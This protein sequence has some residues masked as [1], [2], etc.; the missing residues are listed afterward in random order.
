MKEKIYN[1]LNRTYGICMMVSFFAGG[2]PIIPFIIAVI[3]GGQTGEAI[4]TFLYKSYYPWVI[5][6]ASVSIVIGVVAMYV[7]KQHDFS[8][9]SLSKKEK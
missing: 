4:A 2:L 6:L 7:K 1:V 5:V 9:K 3:I 8:L